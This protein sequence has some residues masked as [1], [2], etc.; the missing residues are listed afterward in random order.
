MALVFEDDCIPAPQFFDFAKHSLLK[1]KDHQ[2]VMHIS[3]TNIIYAN[4]QVKKLDSSYF[5]SRFALPCWG[6]ASWSRAWKKFNPDMDTWNQRKKLLF[7]AIQ[8]KNFESF[9]TFF[10]HALQNKTAWDVQWMIDIWNNQGL[11]IVPKENL[12]SNIGF[13]EQSTFTKN[14]QSSFNRIPV[15]DKKSVINDPNHIQLSEFD[16]IF[17]DRVVDFIKE[18]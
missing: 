9:T 4:D 8:Q 14:S 7:T 10:S 15:P 13:D 12:V 3:G 11:V 16:C 6:W 17:E 18:F 1:Y 2:S 5:F